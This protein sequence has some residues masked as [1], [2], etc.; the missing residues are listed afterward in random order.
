MKIKLARSKAGHDKR[1]VYLIIE[2]TDEYAYLCNG[3]TK[4]MSKPKK[5]KQIHLQPINK[6]PETIIDYSESLEKLDDVSIKR[7]IKLYDERK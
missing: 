7:I 2:E 4:P 5:K 1:Q 6:M 3:T